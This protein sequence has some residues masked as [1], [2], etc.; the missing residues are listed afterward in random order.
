VTAMAFSDLEQAY[1]RLALAIDE[2]GPANEAVFLTKLILSLA[3]R[4]PD[5]GVFDECLAIART[6]LPQCDAHVDSGQ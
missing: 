3:H 1:E 6:D 5:L 2:V 4:M